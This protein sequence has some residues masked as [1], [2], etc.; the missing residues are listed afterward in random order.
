MEL[1]RVE[2]AVL[3]RFTEKCR[4]AGG[5]QP[6]QQMRRATL[7]SIAEKGPG[8]DLDDAL[9]R[10]VEKGLLKAN[11]QADRYFL[12]AAGAELLRET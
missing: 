10:L 7:R 2:S 9:V 6:G 3:A 12:T 8:S 5:P 4:A 1:S 11:E